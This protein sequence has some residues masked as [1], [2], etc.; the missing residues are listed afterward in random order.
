MGCGGGLEG[1]EGCLSAF[2]DDSWERE[3]QPVTGPSHLYQVRGRRMVWL[4]VRLHSNPSPT[5]ASL[6]L[7]S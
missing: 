2:Y 3:G 4:Q 1:R 7:W 5:T 6:R